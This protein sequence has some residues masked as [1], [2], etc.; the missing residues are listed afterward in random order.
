MLKP[1]KVSATAISRKQ[2]ASASQTSSFADI[3]ASASS[4]RKAKYG[5]N[6]EDDAD[7]DEFYST[8]AFMYEDE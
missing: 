8:C 5:P 4:T 6:L 1:G 3:T 2:Q 7:D